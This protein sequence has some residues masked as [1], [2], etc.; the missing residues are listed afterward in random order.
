MS[1]EGGAITLEREIEDVDDSRGQLIASVNA[2]VTGGGTPTVGALHEGGQYFRGE[3]LTDMG[4]TFPSPIESACQ[5]NHIVLLTDGSPSVSG[6]TA[7]SNTIAPQTCTT[8]DPTDGTCGA[9]LAAWLFNTDHSTTVPEANN[10][11]THTIGFSF[12]S[13][14]LPSLS[15]AGNGLHFTTD[16]SDGLVA[17]FDTILGAADEGGNVFAAPAIAV[18]QTTR[19]SHRKDIYLALFEPTDRMRWSGNLKKYEFDGTVVDEDGNAAIDP[20]EGVIVKPDFWRGSNNGIS[21][22]DGGAANL[23]GVNNPR[24][25]YTYTGP[26]NE[27]L[28]LFANKLHEDNTLITAAMLNVPEAEKTKLIQWGRGLDVD[29]NFS[30]ATHKHMADPLHSRPTV[31]TYDGG[32]ADDP[33]SVVF[34]G[35]N[36]GFLHAFNSSDGTE[37]FSFI[38]P[39][40][41]PNLDLYYQNESTVNRAYGLDG[42]LTLWVND[43]DSDGVIET[44]QSEHA[45]LFMGMRRGGSNY[46]ALDISVKDTPEF[47]WS[48]N[49]GDTGFEKLGQSWSKPT[50]GRIAVNGVPTDG[51][52]FGGGYDPMQDNATMRSPDTVGNDLFIVD[53]V[54]KDLLWNTSFDPDAF[55][56]MDYSMPSDPRVI[57]AN[58]DGLIDQIYIGDMGGQVWRF[59]IDNGATT[60][61]PAVTGGVIANLSGGESTD[62][63]RFFYPPDVTLVYDGTSQFLSVSIGSGNRAHPKDNSVNNRFYM[64][65]QHSIF[66]APEGYGVLDTQDDDNT[67]VVDDATPEDTTPTYRAMTEGDLYNATANL[68]DSD[69]DDIATAAAD[70]L[71]G[72]DGWYLE[73][74]SG[75]KVLA[76]SITL[77]NRLQARCFRLSL[78]LILMKRGILT[79]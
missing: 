31:M 12:T 35:T 46:T 55:S 73:L 2:L 64:I 39:E 25:V 13:S 53:A 26:P 8:A 20:T 30:G 16:S 38:P 47:L 42:D 14:W 29:N 65:R 37:V 79:C 34:V 4:T 60:D 28:T 70:A 75:E 22:T 33:N 72:E 61:D 50:L 56:A 1:Y 43:T 24:P 41:L 45:Y 57:D 40:L 66:H 27:D 5:S 36:E 62:N 51:L 59:D 32:T 19:L 78:S 18:D 68:I 10:I 67:A 23:L 9:E 3:P 17:A 48:I 49:G 69:D 52:I 15:T 77:K 11:I 74:S 44:A 21:L 63:R 7:A 58:G 54:S 76:S 6:V 71:S